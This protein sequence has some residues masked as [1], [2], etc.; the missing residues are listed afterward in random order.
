MRL[1]HVLCCKIQTEKFNVQS[2]LFKVQYVHSKFKMFIQSS[3]CS[4]KV[5]KVYSMFKMFIQSSKSLFKVQNVHSKYKKFIQSSKCS[6]KVQKVYSKFKMFI[7]LSKVYSMFK[8]LL[9]SSTEKAGG[10]G[11]IT[12]KGLEMIQYNNNRGMGIIRGMLGKI[13]DSHVSLY[14]YVNSEVIDKSPVECTS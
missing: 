6:F 7:Q 5:Q 12:I 10:G 11:V 4:F 14:I 13:E 9:L 1:L 8:R 2:V 3:I